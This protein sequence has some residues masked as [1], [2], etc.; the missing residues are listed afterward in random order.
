MDRVCPTA[1]ASMLTC[2]LIRS[3]PLALWML[4]GFVVLSAMDASTTVWLM[5]RGTAEAN[6]IMR[7]LIAQGDAWFWF[8]KMALALLCVVVLEWAYL[9]RRISGFRIIAAV[10]L[11]QAVIVVN[12][13]ILVGRVNG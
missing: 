10:Y 8:G 3:G 2:R 12:N 4:A 6:P 13:L 7:A 5:H 1:G 9:N 11:F